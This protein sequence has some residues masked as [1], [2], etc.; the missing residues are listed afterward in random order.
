M[1]KTSLYRKGNRDF[2]KPGVYIITIYPP[3]PPSGLGNLRGQSH[4]KEVRNEWKEEGK[5]KREKGKK[6][7]KEREEKGEREAREEGKL[8]H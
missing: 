3:P 5:R 4:P 2:P 6:E 7:G 1:M 8:Y